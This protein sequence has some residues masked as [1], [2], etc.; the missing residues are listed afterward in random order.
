MLQLEDGRLVSGSLDSTVKV[1]DIPSGSC[2]AT[3]DH[4]SGVHYLAP[5]HGSSS[6]RIVS[7]CQDG[8]LRI[9][10]T[11]TYACL[12]A[13]AIGN[14]DYGRAISLADGRFLCAPIGNSITLSL[15]SLDASEEKYSSSSFAGKV[16]HRDPVHTTISSGFQE[17]IDGRPFSSERVLVYTYVRDHRA[18]NELT[19]IPERISLWSFPSSQRLRW[20]RRRG[21]LLLVHCSYRTAAQ[22]AGDSS[23]YYSYGNSSH[24]LVSS[25]AFQKLIR[26]HSLVRTIAQL[27]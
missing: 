3:L 13:H 16:V 20:V 21:W 25:P 12:S 27:L 6:Q 18:M 10:D 23:D 2:Q 7:G 22:A 19:L 9:W 1:W 14:L 5:L 8:S 4:P 15:W 11:T 26:V 24:S 17:Q